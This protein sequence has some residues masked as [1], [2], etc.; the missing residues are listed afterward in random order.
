[1]SVVRTGQWAGWLGAAAIAAAGGVGLLVL[2][3][4]GFV[5]EVPSIGLATARHAPLSSEPGRVVERIRRMASEDDEER[6]SV[7]RDRLKEIVRGSSATARDLLQLFEENA[8]DD[9]DVEAAVLASLL[10]SSDPGIAERALDAARRRELD[11][12]AP[13]DADEIRGRLLRE[14]DPAYIA[15][16]RPE[17]LDDLAV[18]LEIQDRAV[19]DLDPAVRAAAV[20]ALGGAANPGVTPFLLFRLKGEASVEVRQA[21]A[22]SLML[23]SETEAG[24][25]LAALL[26]SPHEPVPV[27]RCAA[28]AL[29]AHRSVPTAKRSLLEALLIDVDFTVRSSAAQSLGIGHADPETIGALVLSLKTDASNE[30]R[31]AA[32]LSLAQTPDPEVRLALEEAVVCDESE[33]VRRSAATAL[34]MIEQTTASAFGN[35]TTGAGAESPFGP[36]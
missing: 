35:D 5:P 1:M 3:S 27:R 4:T 26:S 20:K 28:A 16:L 14:T 21:L 30:V 8:F 13:R 9:R 6:I 10:A 24:R 15:S 11:Y 22:M 31:S 19:L 33:E 32:A 12:F 34:S 29:S 36:R 18:F 2:R 23:R 7:E 17:D 25:E